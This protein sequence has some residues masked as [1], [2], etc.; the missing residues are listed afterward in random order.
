MQPVGPL[1]PRVYW[2]RRTLVIAAAVV[3]LIGLVWLLV[4]KMA[5]GTA[6]DNASNNTSTTDS[7]TTAG[8]TGVL[9]TGTSGGSSAGGSGPASTSKPAASTTSPS[10]SASKPA[11]ASSAPKTSGSSTAAPTSAAPKSTAPKSAAPKST[12]PAST[13]PK[14][15]PPASTTPTDLAPTTT[16]PV[17]SAPAPIRNIPE[18]PATSSEPSA[19]ATRPTPTP[20]ATPTVKPAPT[21]TSKP[22]AKPAS[23]PVP[24]T[25]AQGRPLCSDASINLATTSRSSSFQVGSRPVLGLT[26]TNRGSASCVRDVSGSLQVFTVYNAQHQRVWS[27]VDCFPGQGR[28]TQQI[29]PGQHLQFDIKWAGTTSRPGCAGTRTPVPAGSYTAVADLGAMRAA[30]VSFTITG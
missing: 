13:T 14:S 19:S 22:A 21:P 12:P 16:R 5:G 29:E 1:E 28:Q 10:T 17:Q 26:V 24:T 25:D 20:A 30:P 3:V 11:T 2:I 4:S 18:H 9:A 23:K 6:P 15:T 27:T 7:S 8:L